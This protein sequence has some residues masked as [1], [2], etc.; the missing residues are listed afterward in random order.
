MRPSWGRYDRDG[1][2]LVPDAT[3]IDGVQGAPAD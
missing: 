1:D 2:G 3:D